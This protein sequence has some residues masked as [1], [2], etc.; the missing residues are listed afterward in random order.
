MDFAK[1]LKLA[2]DLATLIGD[3][4]DTTESLWTD[5]LAVAAAFRSHN[6]PAAITAGKQFLTDLEAAGGN[7][8]LRA[9]LVAIFADVGIDASLLAA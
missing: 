6:I 2:G 8:K 4:K 5:G 1:T 9:D 7:A 3:L